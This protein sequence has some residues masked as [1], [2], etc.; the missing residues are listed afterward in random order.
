MG[1]VFEMYITQF[2][3]CE[4]YVQFINYSI[5]VVNFIT[6]SSGSEDVFIKFQ[7]ILQNLNNATMMF[8]LEH[9]N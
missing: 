2:V 3:L 4:N 6:Y 5:I 8:Y 9:F 7:T 1:L